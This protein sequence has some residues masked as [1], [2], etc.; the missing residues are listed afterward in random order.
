MKDSDPRPFKLVKQLYDLCMNTELLEQKGLKPIQDL[1]KKL[2]GWPVVEGNNWSD[3][4]FRWYE[5]MY[6]F[7][8]EG[9]TSNFHIIGVTTDYKVQFINATDYCSFYFRILIGEY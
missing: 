4:D 7:R 2:G 3:E 8:E 1:I 6:K 5:L 9:L